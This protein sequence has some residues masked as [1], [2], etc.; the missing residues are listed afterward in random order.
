MKSAR[1]I[2]YYLEEESF[3]D[4]HF[5]SFPICSENSEIEVKDLPIPYWID[6]DIKGTFTPL[7]IYEEYEKDLRKNSIHDSTITY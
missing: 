3:Y 1:G 4:Y 5:W 2:W 7:V 6:D